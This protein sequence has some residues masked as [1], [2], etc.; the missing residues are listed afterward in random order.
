MNIYGDFVGRLYSKT[1]PDQALVN[2]ALEIYKTKKEFRAYLFNS[3]ALGGWHREQ[4]LLLIITLKRTHNGC[5]P[6]IIKE[7]EKQTGLVFEGKFDYDGVTYDYSK[8]LP[9][10]NKVIAEAILWDIYRKVFGDEAGQ[11]VY[12]ADLKVK[13]GNDTIVFVSETAYGI[14][15]QDAD[16]HDLSTGI[17]E[18]EFR[19][20]ACMLRDLFGKEQKPS[21]PQ[22]VAENKLWDKITSTEFKNKVYENFSELFKAEVDKLNKEYSVSTNL[23][24]VDTE[25]YDEV[26]EEF[27]NMVNGLLVKIGSSKL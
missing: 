4:N 23:D 14:E 17:T 22:A 9:K 11:C 16:G 24:E 2:R 25:W 21:I 12:V 5:I 18:A 27:N 10:S 7:M 1:K 20:I 19:N 15:I 13:A 6:D 26:R 3:G 8:R